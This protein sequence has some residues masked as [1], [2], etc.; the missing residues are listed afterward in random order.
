MECYTAS[1][2][3]E[4]VGLSRREIDEKT[5]LMAETEMTSKNA[6]SANF[7]DDFEPP[8]YNIWSFGKKTNLLPDVTLPTRFKHTFYRPFILKMIDI[9]RRRFTCHT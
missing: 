7:T 2:I 3:A 4:V 9:F 5:T 1:E 8:I 6:Q